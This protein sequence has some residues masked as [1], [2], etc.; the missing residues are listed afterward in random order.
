MMSE[1]ELVTLCNKYRTH[2]LTYPEFCRLRVWVESSEENRR[3]FSNY[4]RLYKEELRAS[5]FSQADPAAAWQAIHRRTRHRPRRLYML[6][7]AACLAGVMAVGAFF[8]YS[9]HA[10]EVPA[11]LPS[12]TLANSFPDVSKNQITLT[13]SSGEQLVLDKDSL[14][15]I[16]DLGA[17]VAS[18]TNTTLDYSKT[19]ARTT[20][21]AP[22]YNSVNVPKGSTFK[23]VLADGTHVTLNSSSMLRYP[24]AFRGERCVELTGEAYFDVAHDG[25]PFVVAMGD[26]KVTVLGTCFNV[27]AYQGQDMVTTLVSGKVEVES[28][29][30]VRQLKPGDQATVSSRHGDIAIEKV[31]TELYTSWVLGRY[32]FARTPLHVILSQLE[33]WYGV[34]MEY[35]NPELR[36]ILFDGTVFRNKPL[37]YS[38][39]IIQAVSNVEFRRE[40]D[41]VVVSC[42]R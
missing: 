35:R 7:A 27:S 9:Y 37:G 17:A 22:R 16:S 8:L 28:G 41:A 2:T 29:A 15:T 1:D 11:V 25:T 31:D 24:V 38:L 6:V 33:L 3:F 39:E 10:G 21:D 12:A 26:R 42:R 19:D 14:Q 4:L 32:D 20:A 5:A 36:N 40:E 34:K 13:L 18:G 30:C 23:L